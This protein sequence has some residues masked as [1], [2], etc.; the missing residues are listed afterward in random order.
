MREGQNAYDGDGR[1]FVSFMFVAFSRT[2]VEFIRH[3]FDFLLHVERVLSTAISS[4]SVFS[5]RGA[6]FP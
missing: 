6:L 4:Q 1:N 3:V 2:S 5:I